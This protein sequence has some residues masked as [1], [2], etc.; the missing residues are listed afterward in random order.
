MKLHEASWIVVLIAGLGL[1]SGCGRQT[2]VPVDASTTSNVQQPLPFSAP[3]SSSDSSA[4]IPV[5]QRAKLP[6]GTPITVRLEKTISSANARTGDKFRAMLDE[7]IVIDGQTVI[8]HGAA[9]VGRVLSAKPSGRLK[10]PG[11]LRVSLTRIDV[12]RSS[13]SLTTSSI[14][15]KGGSHQRR[16]LAMI[17]GGSAAGALIGGVAGGGKGALIGTGAGA[18][19]GTGGAYAT[20]KKEI[21]LGPERKLTFRLAKPLD[22]D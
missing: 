3:T 16:N 12:R 19:A 2:G 21:A 18:G 8:P 5:S 22:V 11:Y 7:A 20:G 10:D 9:V 4:A 13:I 6:A 14:F 1:A 17:G 15:V